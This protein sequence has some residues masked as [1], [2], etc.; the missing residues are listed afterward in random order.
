MQNQ[1]KRVDQLEKQIGQIAEFVGKFRDPGQL[2]S[3]TIPN[4]KGG[5]ESAKAIQ[6]RSGKEVR[7]CPTPSPSSPEEDEKRR[8]EEEE[9]RFMQTKKEE[10]EKDILETFRKVQVNIPLLDAIKQVPRYAKFLKE[11]CTTR[12]RIANKEVNHLIFPADFYV[13]EMEDSSDAPSLPLLLGRPFMKT[14][15]T[16]IDVA[17]GA[18]TM[19]FGGDIIKFNVYD[20]V[21]TP[22]DSHSCFVVDV[23]KDKGPKGSTLTT[24][25]VLRTT[26]G[27]E[28]GVIALQPPNMAE[29]SNRNIVDRAA[30][31]EPSPH[32]FCKSSIP[33]S[34]PIS[35][36]SLCDNA[37][38]NAFYYI[39]I[40]FN[41]EVYDHLITRRR[42]VTNAPRALSA[43]TAPAVSA[44]LIGEPTPLTEATA[45]ASQ[46]KSIA[47]KRARES[48]SLLHHSSSKPFLYR[49]EARRQID[50][51]KDVYIPIEDVIVPEDVGFQIMI[52][53]LDQKYGHC[54]GKVVRG[55]GKAR[56]RETG[57]FASRSTTGEV[58][59]LKEEVTTLKSQ[60]AAQ[61]E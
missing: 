15:Q 36:N 23:S 1:D 52:E 13:L 45:T 41:F 55:M 53:V 26:V 12:K 3:S 25:D 35:T 30:T 51:F 24:K 58:N 21:K 42:S 22:N 44:P 14:A 50:L 9:T 5:F 57:A 17:K 38:D 47:G 27:E 49:L 20:S 54:H 7:A 59:A 11:L 32:Y 2:P 29:T 18:L 61:D 34:I 8:I 37:G 19:E 10:Q 31:F 56:V 16:K 28:L 6:L 48:K 4:P 60:L 46:K 33:I 43:S 39:T 40:M